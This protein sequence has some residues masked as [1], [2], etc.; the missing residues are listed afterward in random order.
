[1]VPIE[2]SKAKVTPQVHYISKQ[3]KNECGKGT[4]R[5]VLGLKQGGGRGE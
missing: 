5:E 4:C 2:L 3:N 1:M